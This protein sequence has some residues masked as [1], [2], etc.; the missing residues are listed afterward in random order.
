MGT[1]VLNLSCI[2]ESPGEFYKLKILDI[3]TPIL[4]ANSESSAQ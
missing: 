3:H 2:A 4:Q 1:M